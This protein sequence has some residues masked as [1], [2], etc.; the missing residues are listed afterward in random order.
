MTPDDTAELQALVPAARYLFRHRRVLWTA[1]GFVGATLV[2]GAAQVARHEARLVRIEERQDGAGVRQARLEAVLER[3]ETKVDR[4]L[5][6]QARIEG[7]FQ[8]LPLHS[9]DD[10]DARNQDR[11]QP[12]GR[13]SHAARPRAGRTA[14]D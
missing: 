3:V 6:G 14:D 4:A 8:A 9:K 11:E 2:A 5:E 13:E 10:D 1:L 12:R 7:Y